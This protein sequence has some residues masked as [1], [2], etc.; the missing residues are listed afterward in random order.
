MFS[1][2]GRMGDVDLR[3]TP[4]NG[5]ACVSVW[6]AKKNQQTGKKPT[7]DRSHYVG[8]NSRGAVSVPDKGQAS[9]Y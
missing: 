7:V 8:K 6:S 9:L 2:F 1:E 5:V 4:R 3:Y